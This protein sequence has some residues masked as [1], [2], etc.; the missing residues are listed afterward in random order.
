DY[1]RAWGFIRTPTLWSWIGMVNKHHAAGGHG[2]RVQLVIRS[3]KAISAYVFGERRPATDSFVVDEFGFTDQ[4]GRARL[5]SLL[6]AA[7][8]DLRKITGWLPPDAARDALPRG[9]VRKRKDAIFM[10]APLSSDAKLLCE[11]EASR[12]RT[13]DRIWMADHI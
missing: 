4:H 6:R 11:E 5:P 2:Q 1:S 8:G 13:G 12:P 9:S 7:A 10:I 3:G